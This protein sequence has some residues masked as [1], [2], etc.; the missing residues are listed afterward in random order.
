M[1][2]TVVFR[3]LAPSEGLRE[4]AERKLA[5]LGRL[6]GDGAEARVVLTAD[7]FR[8]R[9][10]VALSAR[11]LAAAG[12]EETDD[13]YAAIDLVV[14]KLERQ[15]AETRGRQRTQRRTGEA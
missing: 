3:H 1:H 6:V 4:Y 2:V 11:H 8:R 14:D 5:R 15:A 10:E 7:K 12:V 13:M 9:A